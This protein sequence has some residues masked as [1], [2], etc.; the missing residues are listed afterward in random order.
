MTLKQLSARTWNVL[1]ARF[2][3]CLD[4]HSG[5]Y[6]SLVGAL[7]ATN[8]ELKF[9]GPALLK[10]RTRDGHELATDRGFSN[11]ELHQRRDIKLTLFFTHTVSTRL[12]DHFDTLLTLLRLFFTHFWPFASSTAPSLTTTHQIAI[13]SDRAIVVFSR[14]LEAVLLLSASHLAIIILATKPLSV[15]NFFYSSTTH[16]QPFSITRHCSPVRPELPPQPQNPGHRT[17]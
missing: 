9:I 4:V 16:L 13:T 10:R 17:P 3:A 8:P 5:H 11:A 7:P 6:P 2:G 15:K 14:L 1:C 12:K